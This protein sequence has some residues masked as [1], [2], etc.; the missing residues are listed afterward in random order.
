MASYVVGEICRTDADA[1]RRVRVQVESLLGSSRDQLAQVVAREP[2]AAIARRLHL[3]LV[4]VVPD[5]VNG[6]RLGIEA[7]GVLVLDAIAIRE[8][9]LFYF[10]L[11]PPPVSI[12]DAPRAL[13]ARTMS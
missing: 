6:S 2:L 1:F 12:K 7:L 5:E 3:G 11:T 9:H 10:R 8:L 4:A 13:T